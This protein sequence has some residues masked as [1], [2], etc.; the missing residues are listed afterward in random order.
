[1]KTTLAMIVGTRD[2]FPAEPVLGARREVLS[3]LTGMGVDVVILDEDATNMGAVETWE[4]AKKCAA[5]FRLHRDDID[6]ILVSLPVFAPE[7]GIADAIKL[8][9]LQ[10]P[11]LVQAYPDPVDK[12]GLK[13]RGDAYCGKISLTNNLYQYGYPFTV[14]DEHTVHPKTESFVE[15]LRRFIGVCRVVRGLRRARIGAVGARPAIF[16]T[17]RYSEKLLQ[18]SGITV[19]TADLSEIFGPAERLADDDARVRRRLEGIRDY[20]DTSD[21]PP[22]PLLSMAKFGVVLDD[23]VAENEID[24]TALQCWTSVQQN[25]GINVC[26]LMSMMSDVLMPSGCEVDVTGVVTMYALQLASGQ[27]SALVDWNNNYGDDPD[28]C[29]LF[30]CGNWAKSFFGQSEVKMSYGEI[31]ATV[32]GQDSTYGSVSGQAVPAPI[33]FARITTD[34]R[35]GKI[36]TYVGEGRITDDPLDTFGSRAVVEISGL[37]KLMQYIC[38]NGYEHHTAM[39]ASRSAAILH[40]AFETYM[41]WEVYHH[42]SCECSTC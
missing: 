32:L 38:K 3:L 40:E 23:W 42:G 6:G 17:V 37:K 13:T 29:V 33:T 35:R 31:L 2:F 20:I 25:Y 27:P 12:L 5:L 41:G 34:D 9:E 1:M 36:R 39:N 30:H 18:D 22:E 4:D 16:N 10:V 8:S 14:T 26:T 11:I 24:A 15:D 28:K 21:I 19:T 7:R